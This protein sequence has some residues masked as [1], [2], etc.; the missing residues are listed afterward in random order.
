[1]ANFLD[2]F[3]RSKLFPEFVSAKMENSYATI[4]GRKVRFKRNEEGIWFATEGNQRLQLSNLYRGIWLYRKGIQRRADFIFHSYCL[5]NINFEID[6][7][8]IDCG[9]NSG[10]LFLRLSKIIS[11]RNYYAFEPNPADFSALKFNVGDKANLFPAALGNVDS[12]VV[13]YS[14]TRGGG[15][16]IIEPE[17]YEGKIEVPVVRLD[18]FISKNDIH[19][20][21]LLKLEAEGFE[22]EILEG[23]GA[24]ISRCEYLAIDGGYERGKACEQTLTTCTNYLLARNFEMLDVYFP[25]HRALYRKR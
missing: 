13:L 14:Y 2:R 19:K 25:W 22:P 8:V 21:K 7:V 17:N 23:L 20:V 18:N 11:P 5:D 4:R 3:H 12:K 24:M 10:D 1:M 16:S 15:S 6:D 9:A